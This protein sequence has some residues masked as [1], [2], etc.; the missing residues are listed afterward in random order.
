MSNNINNFPLYKI[1]YDHVKKNGNKPLSIHD[2][3]QFFTFIEKEEIDKLDKHEIIYT[4]IR[5]YDLKNT[6]K[7]SSKIFDIP[8]N[9]KEVDKN[10]YTFEFN[11]LPVFLQ[12]MLI[13][14]VKINES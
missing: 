14:F 3:E 1:L 4:I 6:K 10:N 12:K 5:I 13:Q 2:K 11:K 9:G 8:Y 7:N